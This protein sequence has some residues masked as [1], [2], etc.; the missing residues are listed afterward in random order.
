M[1]QV[2]KRHVLVIAYYFPPLGLSGVQRVAKL[3]KYLPENGWRVT[4]L[5]PETASYFAFDNGLL[6][7]LETNPDIRI[8]R[9]ASLDPTRLGNTRGKQTITF[10]EERSRQFLSTLSQWMLLPDN[11][12]GWKPF[13]VK[14]AREIMD[15]DP[16]DL[17]FAT[18][19]P[20]T[21]LLIGKAIATKEKLPLVVDYRDDWVDNPRH[22]YPTAWHRKKSAKMENKVLQG[23]QHVFSINESISSAIKSR[24]A[25]SK[26]TYSVVPHGYDPEDF[27]RSKHVSSD[28]PDTS[29]MIFLYSGMFY[30]AQQPDSMLAACSSLLQRRKDLNGRIKFRFVGLFPESKLSLI[31]ELGLENE[32]ECVGYLDHENATGQLLRCDVAWM[33]VGHQKGQEMIST[34]KLFEYMGSLKPILALL[35]DGAAKQALEG[36]NAATIV[37]PDD[38]AAIS[39]AIE[40]LY[41][42]WISHSLPV[43]SKSH[44]EQFD[45]KRQ[46]SLFAR[47]FASKIS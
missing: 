9:T 3:V 15:S 19:P 38:I 27:V 22:T 35:P 29:P 20:Y 6:R 1:S 28:K 46:A 4:V 45:R 41:E 33:I 13:A 17:V 32:V 37:L 26:A 18:A 44:V 30:D 39:S 42:E 31:K 7:D 43:G 11:K 2:R 16:F 25:G 47:E 36:Y 21:C 8:V 5:T 10:P 40:K 24:N 34:G 12:I 23:C 14:K